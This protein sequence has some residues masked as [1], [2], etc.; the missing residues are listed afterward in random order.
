M[1]LLRQQTEQLMAALRK[2]PGSIDIKQD[3]NNRVFTAMIDVDQARARRVGVTSK[4]VADTLEFFVDGSTTTNFHQG[5]IQIPIVG[6]GIP[7][8]RYSPE[9]L[10]TLGINPSSGE[11][12]VPLNQVAD[13]F[14][15]PLQGALFRKFRALILNLDEK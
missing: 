4:D 2:I 14:T 1:V 15:K 3:W 13:F 7:A 10:L 6:R 12:S 9:D 11:G 5:N 8:E